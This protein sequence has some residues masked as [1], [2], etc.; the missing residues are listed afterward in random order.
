[1]GQKHPEMLDPQFP[2]MQLLCLLYVLY[3]YVLKNSMLPG[4]MQVFGD[5]CA[6]FNIFKCLEIS[7]LHLETVC[8]AC[9]M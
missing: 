7:I 3:V 1:M 4:L 6:V 8:A 5:R 9:V 2:T